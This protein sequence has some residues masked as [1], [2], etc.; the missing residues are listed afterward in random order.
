MCEFVKP[1]TNATNNEQ[2]IVQEYKRGWHNLLHDDIEIYSML[3]ATRVK[4]HLYIL[5]Q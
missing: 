4:I 5:I 1:A 3:V 2:V